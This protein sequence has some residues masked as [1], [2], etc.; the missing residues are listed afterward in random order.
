MA[1]MLKL[2]FLASHGGSSM[3]AIL[4]AIQ[5][6]RLAAEARLVISNN[7]EAP[8]LAHARDAGVPSLHLSQTKLGAGADVDRAIADALTQHGVDLV[9]LSGYLRKL[10]PAVLGRYRGRILNIHP[11]LLPRYGGQGMYGRHVH[12][13]VIAAGE[14]RSGITIHVVDEHYD[15]GPV[16]AQREVPLEAGDT[17][18]RL[19]QRIQAQE[20]E[21]FV[22]TLRRVT[23]GTLRLPGSGGVAGSGERA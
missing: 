9:V 21:F 18:E 4:A 17:P 12:E 10:G 19:A 14:K 22:E 6:G 15:H 16:V 1:T 2:G 8:A 13:A 3:R 20:P 5:S 7:A 23:E 11:G